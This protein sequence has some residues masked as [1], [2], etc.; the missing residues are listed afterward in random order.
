MKVLVIPDVHLKPWM[1]DRAENV[2]QKRKV[3][4]IV[5]LMD[6]PDDWGQERN[7]GL[8]AETYDRVIAFARNHP[9]S[10]W[11]YGNHDLSYMWR[12]MESGYSYYTEETVYEKQWVVDKAAWDEQVKTGTYQY[13]VNGKPVK[14]KLVAIG[15]ET[16]YFDANG[17]AVTGWKVVN[18]SRMYFGSDRKMKTGWLSLSGKKYYLDDN[19]KAQTGW[20]T[21]DGNT[22]YFNRSDGAMH[23]KW[24]QVDGKKYYLDTD[25]TVHKGWLQSGDK[26]YYFRV[27]GEMHTGMLKKDCVYYYLEK[28]GTRHSGWLQT[29]GQMYYFKLNGQM[30]TGWLQKSGKKYYFKTT[31]QMHTGWLKLNKR[32]SASE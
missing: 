3:D 26:W 15:N 7:V 24:L 16:Y 17:I 12:A 28:D 13:I 2:I 6:I 9:A 23:T 14:N 11:C 5:C 32:T 10:L 4:N 1:F 31:G 22:Y 18:G 19:G 21:V 29:G 20:Q 25:G 8:Y 27:N 30:L